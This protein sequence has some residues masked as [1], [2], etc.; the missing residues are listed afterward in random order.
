VVESIDALVAKYHNETGGPSGRPTA[1]PLLEG[2]SSSNAPINPPGGSSGLRFSE[3]APKEIRLICDRAEKC[4]VHPTRYLI[5]KT[6]ERERSSH[7]HYL[8][9][10]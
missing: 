2:Y 3:F 1:N 9:R 7:P 10:R 8:A 4:G 5:A 6:H